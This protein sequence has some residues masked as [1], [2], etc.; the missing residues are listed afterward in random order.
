MD[1]F[2]NLIQATKG[3]DISGTLQRFQKAT[4]G[5]PCKTCGKRFDNGKMGAKLFYCSDAC[6]DKSH[7]NR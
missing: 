3:D 2:D 6:E 1:K 7:G 5:V 4:E